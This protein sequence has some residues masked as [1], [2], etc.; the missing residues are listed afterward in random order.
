MPAAAVT[1]IADLDFVERVEYD[2]EM[3]ALGA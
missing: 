3:H 1:Q 2:G